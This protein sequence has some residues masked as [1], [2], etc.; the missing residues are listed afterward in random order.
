VIGIEMDEAHV[1][2]VL[3]SC[4]L[5]DDEMARGAKKW[6]RYD[7]PLAAW[8]LDGETAAS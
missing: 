3:D 7:D 1:R 4:L 2:R 6:R 8:M 5:T